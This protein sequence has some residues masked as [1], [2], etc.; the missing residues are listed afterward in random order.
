MESATIHQNKYLK[1][2]KTYIDLGLNYVRS[3]EGMRD[4][5]MLPLF[6]NWLPFLIFKSENLVIR[7]SAI[8]SMLFSFYFFACFLASMALNLIPFIGSVFANIAHLVGIL[9]YLGLSGFF[10]YSYRRNKTLDMAVIDKHYEYIVT[11][12]F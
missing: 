12:L 3:E 7:K 1:R 8:Y 9:A 4:I 5:A 10:I 2:I 6:F 11:N